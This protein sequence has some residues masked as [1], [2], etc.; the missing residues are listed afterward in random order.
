LNKEA[1]LLANF[2]IDLVFRQNHMSM[3]FRLAGLF[4]FVCLF[5][6]IQAQDNQYIVK[7]TGDT[8]RGTVQI[9]PLRDNSTSM[10]FKGDDGFR[11]NIRPLRVHFVYFSE[12]YQYRSVPFHNNQRLFMQILKE[13]VNISYYNYTHER[14]NSISTTKV[15][16]K[17]NGKALELSALTFRKQVSEFLDD[18]PEI[19]ASLEAK[20]YRYKDYARL[21]D[22]Y[23]E[24]DQPKAEVTASSANNT[25]PTQGSAAPVVEAA[26]VVA[27]PTSPP[28]S[29]NLAIDDDS[30][31][32]KLS[33]VDDF[34]KFVRE[35]DSFEYSKD[36]L[37]W[38]T[39]VEYRIS[40][41]NHI[42][43]Y[44]WSSLNAMTEGQPELQAKA[45][46]LRLDLDD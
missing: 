34:R 15:A 1:I 30:K 31:K 26:V 2:F 43:N 28:Q 10:F 38:L 8:L 23:N 4:I 36:V 19:V 11:G 3:I 33:K 9:N 24:C 44:L 12:E 5:T 37:E 7:I 29:N 35:L 40:Q 18:C 16:S 6:Q 32:E 39:D 25:A 45:T 20:E 13:G 46:Q 27:A 17:P 41:G 42:P 21:F 14:D 22:D